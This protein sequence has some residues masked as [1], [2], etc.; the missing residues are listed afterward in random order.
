MGGQ[1][2]E[3]RGTLFWLLVVLAA[4]TKIFEKLTTER[5]HGYVATRQ[6]LTLSRLKE[7]FV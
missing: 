1:A 7:M 6:K 5:N 3:R 4:Q 2:K